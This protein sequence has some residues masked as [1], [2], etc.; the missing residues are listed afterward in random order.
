MSIQTKENRVA[1]KHL[2]E[3]R[4]RDTT[5]PSLPFLLRHG[6]S[7]PA[8]LCGFF[9]FQF[10]LRASFTLLFNLLEYL[11]EVSE[12]DYHH[13]LL[14][15]TFSKG[16]RQSSMA[17]SKTSDRA[18]RRRARQRNREPEIEMRVKEKRWFYNRRNFISQ[19]VDEPFEQRECTSNL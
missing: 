1:S 16:S 9:P 14:P 12:N 3:A 11:G 5:P 4:D 13:C 19:S 6:R 15:H 17:I 2:S 10:L 7:W 8:I 18:Q